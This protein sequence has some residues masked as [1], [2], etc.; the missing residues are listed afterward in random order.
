MEEN[1]MEVEEL[2]D[3]ELDEVSGGAYKKLPEKKGYIVYHI[4]KGD[5]LTR[6]ANRYGTTV[7]KIQA[8]NKNK[9]KNVNL[10][11]AGDYIYIPV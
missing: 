10:I 6:I 9:I 3:E 2:L 4:V 5:N 8:A 11:R 7:A 1:K